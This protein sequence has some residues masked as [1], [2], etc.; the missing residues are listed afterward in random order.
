MEWVDNNV[1]FIVNIPAPKEL[2]PVKTLIVATSNPNDMGIR[3]HVL[4][5]M[6]LRHFAAAIIVSFN[7][8]IAT[9]HTAAISNNSKQ[10]L[11]SHKKCTVGKSNNMYDLVKYCAVVPA[12]ITAKKALILK[13]ANFCSK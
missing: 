5:V 6:E 2:C 4:P 8:H 10:V 7:I 3:Y 12:T 1:S 11:T 13:P 9:P